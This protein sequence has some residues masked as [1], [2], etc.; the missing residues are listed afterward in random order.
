M[1]EPIRA[2]VVLVPMTEAEARQCVAGITNKLT[3]AMDLALDLYEREGWRAL[4][5]ASW[6]ACVGQELGFTVRRGQQL[7]AAADVRRRLLTGGERLPA[8]GDEQFVRAIGFVPR[9]GLLRELVPLKGSVPVMRAAL[10][11]AARATGGKPTAAAVRRAV[12][13]R[14]TRPAGARVER[15]FPRRAGRLAKERAAGAGTSRRPARF[16]AVPFGPDAAAAVLR[17]HFAGEALAALIAALGEEAH[18]R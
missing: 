13:A 10:A 14:L 5:Y 3:D 17:Q 12:Q 7:A 15:M 6:A 4:G 16:I 1:P 2:A 11:E 8:G 18:G 9:E